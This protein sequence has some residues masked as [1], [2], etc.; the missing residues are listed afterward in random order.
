MPAPREVH[1]RV[2]SPPTGHGCFYG[3][4]T[5]ERSKL[6][7]GRMD[8]GAMCDFIQADSLAF[9]SIDGLYRAVGQKQRN[10]A[11][12]QYLR[13]LLHRRLSHA[14]DRSRAGARPTPRS[15]PSRSTR[16]PDGTGRDRQ[17][18]RRADRAC[19]RCEPRDRRGHGQGAGRGRRA[20]HADRA[21][22][23]GARSRS[24]TRSTQAGGSATIAPLDLGEPD[25]IARLAAAMAN[26]WDTLDIMVISAALSAPAG[27]GDPD[28]PQELQ[29]GASPPI[30][31]R[32]RRCSPAFDPLL[33]AQRRMRGSSG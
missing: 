15:S 31:W 12:P 22:C 19:H 27:P 20:C 29:P 23:Q 21:R 6:L 24:K 30:C 16:S 25:A 32:P 5:P 4:D 8:V 11:C 33:Q 2:A 17:A 28:R 18:L 13:C 26:R 3:V 10:N 14:A 7:A 1:F 9:V